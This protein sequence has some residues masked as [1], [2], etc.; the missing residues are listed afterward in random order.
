VKGNVSPDKVDVKELQICLQR[1]N[2]P[3]PVEVL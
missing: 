2:V 1:Q 3:L